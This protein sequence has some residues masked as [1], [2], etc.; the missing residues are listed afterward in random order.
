MDCEVVRQAGRRGRFT[1]QV[2]RVLMNTERAYE[3]MAE[4]NR[5]IEDFS[6]SKYA[7]YV[8]VFLIEIALC[9]VLLYSI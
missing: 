6:P 5:I 1:Q 4:A 8:T 2:R 9:F 7:F 3:T